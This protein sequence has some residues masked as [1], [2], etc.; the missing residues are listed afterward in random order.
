MPSTWV[1]SCRSPHCEPAARRR[2]KSG[3]GETA[4]MQRMLAAQMT[5]AANA[6]SDV[7]ISA[8]HLVDISNTESDLCVCVCM[9]A[10]L[11]TERLVR[12]VTAFASRTTAHLGSEAR[13]GCFRLH[14]SNPTIG[15]FSLSRISVAICPLE[16]FDQYPITCLLKGPACARARN[17]AGQAMLAGK[18]RASNACVS[19]LRICR[20]PAS[21]SWRTRDTVSSSPIQQGVRVRLIILR[22]VAW[23][24]S[25]PVANNSLPHTTLID[26]FS[27]CMPQHRASASRR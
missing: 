16:K 23:P 15:R 19:R 8:T 27:L 2:P 25:V 11:H 21:A 10:R 4:A 12:L 18:K 14:E 1:V 6:L 17:A 26:R 7:W 22:S 9:R 20:R 13:H 5:W 3:G 24:I